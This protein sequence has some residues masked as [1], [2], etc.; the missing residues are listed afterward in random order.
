[1]A[2]PKHTHREAAAAAGAVPPQPLVDA[3]EAQARR[4]ARVVRQQAARAAADRQR[5]MAQLRTGALIAAGIV[6]VGGLLGFVAL[7]EAGKPGDAVVQQPSPHLASLDTPHTPYSTQPPTSGPHTKGLPAWGVATT[8]V[9]YMLQVHGLE[10]GGVVISYQPSLA[11]D[12][13]TQLA[14][15]AGSYSSKII[16]TP[17]PNIG[18]P[19]VVTAWGRI[20]RFPQYDETGL[21]RFIDAF[22]GVDHHQDSGS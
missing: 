2:K 1:M 10:D 3:A 8:P 21:R 5:R 19:I 14:T 22:R 11:A 16:L 9:P 17:D 4:A 7:R 13:V 6:L 12:T 18:V 20:Q 15:L